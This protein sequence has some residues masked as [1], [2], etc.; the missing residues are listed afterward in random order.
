MNRA[1]VMGK[2][3]GTGYGTPSEAIYTEFYR[4]NVTN[5]RQYM[6]IQVCRP[7]EVL[8]CDPAQS[9]TVTL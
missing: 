1:V 8:I 2:N 4:E 9:Q 3:R 5:F 6:H 7:T